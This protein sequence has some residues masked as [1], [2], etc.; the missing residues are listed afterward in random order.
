[1]RV[2]LALEISP[3][4]KEYL[5]GIIK[6]MASRITG[7]RWVKSEGQHITLKFFGELD[8]AMVENIR[9]RLLSIDD[10][11]EPF[12]ATI[13]GIDAFPNKRRARVI[14]VTLEKG[15]DIAKAIF[16]DI[17]VALLPLGFEG[18]KRDYTPHITLG[19]K[20][21][22]SPILERDIP[23]LNGMRFIV[24]RL[25]MFR[26]TLTPQGAIYSP[27][28]EIGFKSRK[29]ETGGNDEKT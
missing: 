21:E 13:K 10:K 14:V 3:T 25:V 23:D 28:W 9:T 8:E 24:D 11:F 20:K 5:Q 4:V 15:V 29:S 19:R 17:E 22:Q 6:I 16:N 7:V 27:L 1:M 26:S 18:E 2:F 12:E